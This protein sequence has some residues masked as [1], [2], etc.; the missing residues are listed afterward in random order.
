MTIVERLWARQNTAMHIPREQIS[1]GILAGG[2]GRRL[3][4]IDKGWYAVDGQPLIERTLAR[5]RPQVGSIVVSANR[6]LARYRALGYP[7]RADEGE[8]SRGPLAGIAA[9][10]KTASTPYVLIVPVDTPWLPLD[11]SRRLAAAL[12]PDH[13][14]AVARADGRAHVLHA[15]MHRSLLMDLQ[16]AIVAGTRRVGDW[17]AGLRAVPVDWD[18]AEPFANINSEDDVPTLNPHRD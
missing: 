13:D 8:D 10:L 7:V 5:V 9:L 2:Q 3:G 11:L 16:T 17:Q 4:G 15:L 18:S 12:G 14:I 1:A 6:S